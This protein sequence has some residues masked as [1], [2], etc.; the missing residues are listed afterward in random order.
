MG[1]V[2]SQIEEKLKTAF[3]PDYLEVVD[4]SF[5]TPVMAVRVPKVKRIFGSLS[6][7]RR[8]R[9]RRGSNASAV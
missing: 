7:R 9:A 4:E 5:C 2:A 3:A 6:W 1:N 8:L